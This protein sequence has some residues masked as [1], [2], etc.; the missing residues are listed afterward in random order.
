MKTRKELS[1]EKMNKEFVGGF[2]RISRRSFLELPYPMDA[3]EVSDKTMKE[4]VKS[5]ESM[6]VESGFTE[7]DFNNPEN[8]EAIDTFTNICYQC[9]VDAHMQFCANLEYEQMIIDTL[10]N[11]KPFKTK[12]LEII[13]YNPISL[14][15]TNQE[16]T[17]D[18]SDW[19][20]IEGLTYKGNGKVIL[21]IGNNTHDNISEVNMKDIP[22][23]YYA[24]IFVELG[25]Y[26]E[27][28]SD[29]EAME[30]A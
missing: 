23:F 12:D 8:S 29:E 18:E 21:A 28:K 6:F 9:G 4:I 22:G 27:R 16:E 26:F 10:D 7:Y 14:N 19:M 15:I 13:F 30:N 11:H 2:I 20:W 3:T 24:S 5:I 1:E 17:T 25:E